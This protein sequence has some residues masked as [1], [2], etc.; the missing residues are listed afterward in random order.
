MAALFGR[1]EVASV[2]MYVVVPSL[3]KTGKLSKEYSSPFA[4]A[5]IDSIEWYR[6]LSGAE[7]FFEEWSLEPADVHELNK[8][9]APGG[10]QALSN[11]LNVQPGAEEVGDCLWSWARSDGHLRSCLGG[12]KE[13]GNV[14]AVLLTHRGVAMRAADGAGLSADANTIIGKAASIVRDPNL[15]RSVMWPMSFVKVASWWL[16]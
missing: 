2:S 12:G 9:R 13:A 1:M 10:A 7:A 5:F 11:S 16:H 6:D 8:Y 4:A 14:G 3:D 15:I